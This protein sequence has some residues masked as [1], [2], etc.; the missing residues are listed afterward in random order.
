LNCYVCAAESRIEP[1]VATCPACNAGLCLTHVR[2]TASQEPGGINTGCS[3][4]TW[5][6]KS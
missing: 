1:A 6:R 5:I 3:H 2:V 4:D